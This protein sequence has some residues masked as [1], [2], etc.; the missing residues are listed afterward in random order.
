MIDVIGVGALNWDKLYLVEEMAKGRNEVPIKSISESP[1][2]SA[3]NTI[4]GLARLGLKTGFIGKVGEDAEGEFIIHDLQKEGIDTSH[5]IK[6]SGRSGIIIGIVD[7]QG[8]RAL[9]V[10]PGVNDTLRLNEIN[11]LYA[12][13]ARLVHLSSFVGERS[14]NTQKKLM[15]KLKDTRI[16]FSPGMLYARK[17]LDTL[18]LLIQNSE[19]IFLNRDEVKLL[20]GK[21]YKKGAG[22]LIELGAKMVAVTLGKEGCYIAKA[23]ESY[24]V[25]AYSTKV[26]DTTGAGDAFA[27]GFLYGLLAGKNLEVCGRIGNWAASRCI[28]KMGARDGLPYKKD[29]ERFLGDV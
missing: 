7:R 14:Y 26:V 8:E 3:A 17:G 27:T 6:A 22:D 10:H 5:V 4:C 2:G 20:T 24:P 16:S 11:L 15:K 19:V 25:K 12:K 29:L 23:G 21:E 13:S 18:Q 9:Y 1:G 28:S